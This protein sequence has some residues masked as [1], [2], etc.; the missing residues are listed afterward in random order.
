MGLPLLVVIKISMGLKWL[1]NSLLSRACCEEAAQIFLNNLNK[2]LEMLCSCFHLQ[3]MQ[4]FSGQWELLPGLISAMSLVHFADIAGTSWAHTPH[5]AAA[6]T[7]YVFILHLHG[8]SS[9]W[10]ST[11]FQCFQENSQSGKL[12][13]LC[14]SSFC[15]KEIYSCHE[16]L[17]P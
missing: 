7:T 12:E 15:P 10:D 3:H 9:V 13:V 11:F 16:S 17:H 8:E 5:P 2:Q 6:G 14:L 1:S 4:D